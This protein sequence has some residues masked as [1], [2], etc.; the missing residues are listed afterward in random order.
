MAAIGSMSAQLARI[1]HL[2]LR[3]NDIDSENDTNQ[4]ISDKA[5]I[6]AETA[7]E[8]RHYADGYQGNPDPYA[9]AWNAW[10]VWA[11][12]NSHDAEAEF[13]YST[14]SGEYSADGVT[15]G[16]TYGECLRWL[17]SQTA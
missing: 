9:D 1:T 11:A 12:N 2:A 4:Q 7:L 8:I 14:V 16:K 17:Q 5:R 10:Q 3:A 6:V 13:Q 15:L